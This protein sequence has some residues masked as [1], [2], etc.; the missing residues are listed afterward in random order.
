MTGTLLVVRPD[1]TLS[2]IAA[3]MGLPVEYFADYN[4]ISD[5]NYVYAGQVLYY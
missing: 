1:E 2:G 4:G 3:E 5:P